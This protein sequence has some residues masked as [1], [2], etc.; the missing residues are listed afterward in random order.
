VADTVNIPPPTLDAQRRKD[1]EQ[2]QLLAIFH[3]VL[4]GLSLAGEAFIALHYL[5]MH[6]VFTHPEMWQ[7]K[8][9]GG[10]PRALFDILIW[11]YLF[12]GAAL[13]AGLVANALAGTFLR[14]GRHRTFCLIVAALNCVH[15]PF[16]TALGVFTLI[17]LMRDSVRRRYET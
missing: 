13:L 10:P 3:Y 6:T 8:G 15:V 17:V 16:G 11:V 12:A 1:D 9:G 5:V 14:K 4:S 7:G 2:L